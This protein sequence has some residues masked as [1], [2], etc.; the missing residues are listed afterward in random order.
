MFSQKYLYIILLILIGISINRCNSADISIDNDPIVNPIVDPI[1]PTIIPDKLKT[2]FIYDDFSKATELSSKY[3]MNM[4]V[5][6]GADWCPYCQ[7]LK[8]DIKALK[9]Q[10]FIICFIDTDNKNNKN[11]I[12]RFK[13]RSLPTSV[14]I[15]KGKE[16]NRKIG[17]SKKGYDLWL[18]GL[19]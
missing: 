3:D 13:P 15:K 1:V 17:Y 7:D 8:K 9:I 10:K 5:V 18:N 2:N 16:N 6:F 4:I 11:I 19:L 12:S 14:F